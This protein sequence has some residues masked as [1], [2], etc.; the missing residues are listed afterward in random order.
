MNPAKKIRERRIAAMRVREIAERIRELREAMTRI[1]PRYDASGGGGSGGDRMM[2]YAARIDQ[3]ERDLT[4][5]SRRAYR[6]SIETL[7]A[8]GEL[9]EDQYAVIV[10][11]DFLGLSWRRTAE[12]TG[13]GVMRCRRLR[14]QALGH[15]KRG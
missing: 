8:I 6:I 10:C 3:L 12:R 4:R 13:Y 15:K 2:A 11:R 5:A 7:E 14:E 1:T 9:P